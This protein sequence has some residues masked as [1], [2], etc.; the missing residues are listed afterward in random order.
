MTTEAERLNA[1][2]LTLAEEHLKTERI[3]NQLQQLIEL[4]NPARAATES[5]PP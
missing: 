4:L 1:L 2:E 3:E 5:A